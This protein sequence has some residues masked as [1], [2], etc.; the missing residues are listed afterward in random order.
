MRNLYESIVRFAQGQEGQDLVEYAMIT[1]VISVP[2]ILTAIVLPGA[3]SQWASYVASK[4]SG[5]V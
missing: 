2:I 5:L 1:V 4:V 3:F